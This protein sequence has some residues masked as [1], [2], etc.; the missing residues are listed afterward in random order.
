MSLGIQVC[1]SQTKYQVLIAWWVDHWHGTP[2]ALG[3]SPACNLTFPNL[4]LTYSTCYDYFE[5]KLYI[6]YQ[7]IHSDVTL[8]QAYAVRSKHFYV[9]RMLRV[10]CVMPN[11]FSFIQLMLSNFLIS[12]TSPNMT[13]CIKK[14]VS[15]MSSLH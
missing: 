11:L 3:S 9:N 4:Q 8:Q 2:D 5:L 6:R 15:L 7:C 1:K 13:T 12:M 10:Y 14:R